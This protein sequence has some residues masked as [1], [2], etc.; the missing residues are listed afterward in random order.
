MLIISDSA[1][2]PHVVALVTPRG[3]SYKLPYYSQR[4]REQE[5][6]KFF[7]L[8]PCRQTPLLRQEQDEHK[9][10]RK[11]VAEL[12]LA[13]INNGRRSSW[14]CCLSVALVCSAKGW[15]TTHICPPL[16]NTLYLP[17]VV[18]AHVHPTHTGNQES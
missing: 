13:N 8:A 10:H 6:V 12:Y 9:V 1:P 16:D 2:H 4:A 15:F 18:V 5:H 11:H 3:C 14:W 7:L 17:A